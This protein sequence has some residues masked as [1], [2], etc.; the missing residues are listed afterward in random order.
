M[1]LFLLLLLFAGVARAQESTL[2]LYPVRYADPA[3]IAEVV[4]VMMPST[5]GLNVQVIDRKLAVRGTA[6][7]HAVVETMLRE[8]DKP[9]KNVQINVQFARSGQASSHEAGLRQ[10]GPII[11]RNGE[12]HGSFEGRFSNQSTTSNE[13]T[14]QMLVA[15]NGRSATLQIG[16][17]VPYLAW[18]TEYSWRHGYIRETHIEWRNVGSFL[19]VQP[20]IIGAGPMICIRLIPTLSGKLKDGNEQTIQF[21]ELATEVIARDGQTVSIGGFS[22]DEDF[23]SKFLVGRSDGSESSIT[24]ITLT[25]KILP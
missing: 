10:K 3:R 19:A 4:P 25:P 15:M 9:P 8:L 7:Q 23:S 5:N 14:T 12:V 24:D 6:E 16:E 2:T 21:T 20:E 11:I 18:L 1:R 17:T 22:K 13:N